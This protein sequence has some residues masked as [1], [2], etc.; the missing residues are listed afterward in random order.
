VVGPQLPPAGKSSKGHKVGRI[1]PRVF[2]EAVIKVAA[3]GP[4]LT[5]CFN[6]RP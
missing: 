1:F 6:R 3:V 2:K 5:M 4:L